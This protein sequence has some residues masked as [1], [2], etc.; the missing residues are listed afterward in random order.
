[1]AAGL[2]GAQF[3]FSGCGGGGGGLSGLFDSIGSG[4]SSLFGEGSGSDAVGSGGGSVIT[5]A[6]GS[7]TGFAADS[8]VSDFAIVTNPE[9]AS[10]MLFGSGLAGLAIWRRRKSRR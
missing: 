6:S 3:L 1:M 10:M 8:G 4:L 7:D 5:I 9:P 2:I